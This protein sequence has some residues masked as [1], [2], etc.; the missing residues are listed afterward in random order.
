MARPRLR[1]LRPSADALILA[2]VLAIVVGAW[3][4]SHLYEA[5]MR[6]ERD[7]IDLVGRAPTVSEGGWSIKEI[8]VKQGQE[9]RLRLTSQDVT[10]GFLIPDL[11]V[12]SVPIVP[13]TYQTLRFVADRPGTFLY[14]CNVLCSHRHGA[15]IGRIVVEPAS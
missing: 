12:Q 15:M 6:S 13:G 7:A 1:F 2:A 5:R 8:R 14:Y 11:G 4:G 3:L 9:V 10:H